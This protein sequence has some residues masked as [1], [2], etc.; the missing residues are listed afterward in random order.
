MYHLVLLLFHQHY[1]FLQVSD[2]T[3]K[4]FYIISIL[5][6]ESNPYIFVAVKIVDIAQ[7]GYNVTHL[8][9]AD[10]FKTIISDNGFKFAGIYE[11]LTD[12]TA[13]YFARLYASF[14]RGTKEK[15]HKLIRRS[16]L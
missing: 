4:F 10:I 6:F 14:E 12:I 2:K 16:I 9:A 8:Q 3:L 7:I 5:Y 13:V 11:L 1:L 15:Q